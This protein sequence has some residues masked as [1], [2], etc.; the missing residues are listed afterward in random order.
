MAKVYY[1]LAMS[2]G[3]QNSSAIR[4]DTRAQNKEMTA[5]WYNS[6]SEAIDKAS[7]STIPLDG[8]AEFKLLERLPLPRAWFPVDFARG[9]TQVSN[10]HR[11]KTIVH[12]R[13][14]SDWHCTPDSICD[15]NNWLDWTA[16]VDNPSLSQDD[17]VENNK[18]DVELD[19]GILDLKRPSQQNLCVP[20]NVP[21]LIWLTWRF[22]KKAANGI[23][24]VSALETRRN[25]GYNK[26]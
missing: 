17:Q 16:Y 4:K 8:L 20:L 6:N 3:S 7:W 18:S 22:Q 13:A 26:Q 10:V 12:H 21:R 23:M 14:E 24:I 9:W 11:P 1:F 2:Q 25:M 5:I 19:P 15:T